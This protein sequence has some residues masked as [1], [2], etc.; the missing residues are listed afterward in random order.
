MLLI[1]SSG[2]TLTIKFGYDVSGAVKRGRR[3][4]TIHFTG[5]ELA[6]GFLD[7]GPFKMEEYVLKTQRVLLS[8]VPASLKRQP[9]K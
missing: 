1:W 9:L 7:L 4:Q 2:E 8:P 3:P 5:E 6:Q